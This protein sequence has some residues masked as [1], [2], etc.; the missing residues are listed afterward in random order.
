MNIFYLKKK[1]PAFNRDAIVYQVKRHEE[2]SITYSSNLI[3]TQTMSV[4][5]PEVYLVTHLL[6]SSRGVKF[7]LIRNMFGRK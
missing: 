4:L 7:N 5:Y 3:H 2:K 1:F 6:C